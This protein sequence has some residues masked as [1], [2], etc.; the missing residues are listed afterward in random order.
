MTYN[1][2]TKNHRGETPDVHPRCYEN[3]TISC[4]ISSYIKYIEK[5]HPE[6]NWLWQRARP[7]ISGS[8]KCW[9]TKTA[10]G[11][12]HLGLMMR[13]ISERLHLSKQFTNHSVRATAITTLCDAGIRDRHIAKLSVHRSLHSIANYNRDCS[14]PQKRNVSA[15]LQGSDATTATTCNSSTR[16]TTSTSVCS[17]ATCT[18][19][20]TLS[21]SLWLQNCTIHGNISITNNNYNNQ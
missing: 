6:N 18:S 2:F 11:T 1:E 19:T 8:E 10:V 3:G 16:S 9:Y 4:P 5:L 14:E 21:S 17:T 15:I 12:N 13:R 20:T 7:R